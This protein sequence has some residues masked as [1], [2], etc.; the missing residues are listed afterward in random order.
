MTAGRNRF[1]KDVSVAG[2]GG[3]YSVLLD[4]R[5]VKTPA[6]N[7]LTLPNQALA[8]ALAEEW[9]GQGDQI[10]PETMLL[11][12]FANTAID[13]VAGL[14]TTVVAQVLAFAKSDVVCYRAEAPA[15]LAERQARAW[16]PLLEWLRG[17]HGAALVPGSGITFIEQPKAALEALEGVIAAHDDFALAG[18]HAV[19][20]L[21]GS[22][23]IALALSEGR[24]TADEAF[25]LSHL[26]EL[27]QAEKW[28]RD[29]EAESLARSKAREL[30]EISRFF[31][32]LRAC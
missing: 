30:I 22:A 12:K 9:R 14:R 27:Y 25:S 6:G 5:P 2:S 13:R 8:G 18:L 32:L 11:T 23:A 15:E 19:A 3:R 21:A 29:A 7:P 17:R 24:L 16:D 1:Y 4:G 31:S 26:D 10:R 20:T 28:G